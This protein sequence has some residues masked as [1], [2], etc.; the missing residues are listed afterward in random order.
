MSDY[1]RGHRII[2]RD[3][4]WEFADTGEPAYLDNGRPCGHCGLAST[5]DG[6][7][8]CLG[9]M[10]G[11][12]NACCGH[13]R[14]DEAYIQ[15]DNNVRLGGAA[16]L[17]A[18]AKWKALQADAIKLSVYTYRLR[19]E[20]PFAGCDDETVDVEVISESEASAEA[21]ATEQLDDFIGNRVG[22]SVELLSTKPAEGEAKP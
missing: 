13:G 9:T 8:G 20:W 5:P 18:I 6:H 16:A 17:S 15:Y 2:H 12:R 10:P 3:G 14:T 21:C 7:D 11:V 22:S 19:I 1:W 4:E